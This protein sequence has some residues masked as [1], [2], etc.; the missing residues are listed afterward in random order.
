MNRT[1][2]P[3]ERTWELIDNEKRR[4]RFIRRIFVAAW[5]VTFLLV[6][7]VAG[8]VSVQVVEMFQAARVN[9]VPWMTVVGSAMPLIDVLWKLSLLV[10]GLSTVAIF[11]R[12]RTASL[13][14]IQLRLSNL[15]EMVAESG[16]RGRGDIVR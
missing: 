8:L 3:M 9:A 11:L 13:A 1:H 14:E 6:L 15:E 4:D 10:A 7:V 16:E 12:L 5:T 2:D